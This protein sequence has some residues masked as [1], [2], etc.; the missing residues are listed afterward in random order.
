[1]KN[2]ALGIMVTV[3]LV[4]ILSSPFAQGMV[5][6]T[7]GKS[8]SFGY[9]MTPAG[10]DTGTLGTFYVPAGE[11]V[12]IMLY[13]HLG[14]CTRFVGSEHHELHGWRERATRTWVPGLPLTRDEMLAGKV[15]GARLRFATPT[16]VERIRCNE[17]I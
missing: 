9:A 13:E 17:L 7:V 12:E 5:N 1:M 11:I 14:I 8:Q 3:V 6:W 16:Q 2:F 15:D 10:P 4:T